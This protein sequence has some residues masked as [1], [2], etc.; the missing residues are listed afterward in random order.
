MKFNN[1]KECV[2]YVLRNYPETTVD[3]FKLIY[4]TYYHLGYLDK[5]KYFKTIM[6]EASK[7]GYNAFES[8]TRERRDVLNTYPE[9]QDE[10]VQQQRKLKEKNVR[11]YYRN[12]NKGIKA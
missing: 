5:H 11:K 8:I 1:L 3:D 4:Y 12:K 9:L 2:E 10:K 7:N 6:I